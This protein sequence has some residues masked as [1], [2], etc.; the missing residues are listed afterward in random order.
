MLAAAFAVPLIACA[1]D[2]EI[3]LIMPKDSRLM[4]AGKV[5]PR[6]P[7]R[8]EGEER[9]SGELL[10]EWQSMGAGGV[11]TSYR[12]LPDTAS[13]ARLP[14][15][16]GYGITS[17]DIRNGKEA[18]AMLMGDAQANQLLLD[19]HAKRVRLRGTFVITDYETSID[20]DAPWAAARVLSVEQTSQRTTVRSSPAPC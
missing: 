11:R 17:I 8:F 18:L 1:G 5:E 9:I 7:R 14:H 4:A 13:A 20:C 10:A 2:G 15:F 3:S 12:M 19:H 16:E 6:E